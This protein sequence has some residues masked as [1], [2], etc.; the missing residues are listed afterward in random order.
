MSTSISAALPSP[1]VPN[2]IPGSRLE[3][4]AEI[5]YMNR[6]AYQL[7]C[8]QNPNDLKKGEYVIFEGG[9]LTFRGNEVDFVKKIRSVK[10]ACYSTCHGII[11]K[12]TS[13]AGAQE[14]LRILSL[15]ELAEKFVNDMCDHKFMN[16]WFGDRSVEFRQDKINAYKEMFHKKGVAKCHINYVTGNACNLSLYCG[17]NFD[18]IKS[19]IIACGYFPVEKEDGDLYIEGYE[20]YNTIY[21]SS[22]DDGT[23]KIVPI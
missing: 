2:I 20:N 11:D 13:S 23:A 4:Q 3:K 1:I 8:Q 15:D 7:Y 12:S 9:Q 6:D 17:W 5:V 21:K 10:E 19:Y 14:G 18:L 16:G 22:K